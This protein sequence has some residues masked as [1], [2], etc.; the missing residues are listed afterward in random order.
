LPFNSGKRHEGDLL[1][2]SCDVRCTGG[3][4]LILAFVW[5]LR[6]G[7]V[8]QREKA[9]VAD[10]RGRKYRDTDQGRTAP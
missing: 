4:T 3:V 2:D 9:Q 5:N 10:P 7:T 1:T 8:V 6:T